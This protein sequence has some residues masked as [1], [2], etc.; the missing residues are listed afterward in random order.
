MRR[1][2][3]RCVAVLDTFW[4]SPGD[5]P[6]APG[7]FRINP[8]NFTGRRLYWLLGHKDLWCTDA[9]KNVV[10]KSIDHGKPDPEWL[11]SN[12]RRLSCDLLLVCGRVAER[13][14]HVCG[15]APDC[16]VVTIPH[17]AARNWTKEKLNKYRE[18]IQGDVH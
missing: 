17:P 15:Y 8:Y 3:T 10:Y 1:V 12:L 5:G 14:F 2:H 13:T 6:N 9:C 11:A 16:R 18:L 4:S 7:M